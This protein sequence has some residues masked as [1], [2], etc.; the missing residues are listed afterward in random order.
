[1]ASGAL[2]QDRP[3]GCRG[4][5]ERGGR[6]QR[7]PGHQCACPSSSGRLAAC[8]TCGQS[9]WAQDWKHP[10]SARAA[11]RL[12]AGAHGA[13]QHLRTFLSRQVSLVTSWR[14][15]TPT[16]LDWPGHIGPPLPPTWCQPLCTVT[17]WAKAGLSSHSRFSGCQ[18]IPAWLH[19]AGTAR[20]EVATTARDQVQPVCALGHGDRQASGGGGC[21]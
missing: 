16:H 18:G 11:L 4:W 21:A 17:L 9:Q 2:A 19:P 6:A 13:A 5:R 1:M 20:R 14:R 3:A 8:Q 10:G 7:A 12:W 15:K